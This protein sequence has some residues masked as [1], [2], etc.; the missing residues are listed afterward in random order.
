MLF[1]S[2][3]RGSGDEEETSINPEPYEGMQ[4]AKPAKPVP[5][6]MSFNKKPNKPVSPMGAARNAAAKATIKAFGFDPRGGAYR[7]KGEASDLKGGAVKSANNGVV[8]NPQSSP[9]KPA[10][11]FKMP[12]I[13]PTQA[14]HGAL[15]ALGDAFSAGFGN[16]EA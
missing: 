11:S 14:M 13:S 1:R 4:K 9:P 16:D 12:I 3:G 6:K 8:A 15:P 2:P 10:S 5:G 7:A